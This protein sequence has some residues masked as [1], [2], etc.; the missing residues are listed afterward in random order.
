[1]RKTLRNLRTICITAMLLSILFAQTSMASLAKD[2]TYTVTIYAGNIGQLSKKGLTYTYGGIVKADKDKIVISNLPYGAEVSYDAPKSV[3]LEDGS[4]Y[5]VKGI[6]KGGLDN[7]T[8]GAANFLVKQ[9]MDYVVAYGIKGEMVKYTVRY[10]D[11]NGKELFPSRT[12][13]GSVGDKPVVAYQYIENYSPQAY[14]LTKTLGNDASTNDFK[15]VYKPAPEGK[16][17]VT[18]VV[19]PGASTGTPVNVNPYNPTRVDYS[20]KTEAVEDTDEEET[21]QPEEQEEPQEIIDLDEEDVPLSDGDTDKDVER[22]AARRRLIIS[23]IGIGIVILLILIFIL[24]AS[25]K[26]KNK[27]KK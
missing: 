18:V 20:D 5:Y 19:V 24:K 12:Y 7:A 8:V 21:V 6:R 16:T 4:K 3:S 10:L 13:Y 11:E 1:M 15:F 2:Y 27:T 17:E 22:A 14:N 9:D 25:K 23:L 26:D